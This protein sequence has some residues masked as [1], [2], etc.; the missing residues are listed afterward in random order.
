MSTT[1]PRTVDIE[2]LLAEAGFAFAVVDRCPDPECE[3]CT[4]R[5]VPAAA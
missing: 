3:V 2:Q 1:A 4:G 5:D